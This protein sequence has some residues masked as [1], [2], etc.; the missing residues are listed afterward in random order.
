MLTLATDEIRIAG[1]QPDE[2]AILEEGKVWALTVLTKSPFGADILYSLAGDKAFIQG[3]L[4]FWKAQ[5]LGQVKILASGLAFP[6]SGNSFRCQD[7]L[8]TQLEYEYDHRDCPHILNML[9]SSARQA[10]VT[11]LYKLATGT[12]SLTKGGS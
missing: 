5:P 10:A 11:Y 3:T 6:S 8:I 9:Y 7:V 4:D 1:L 12:H 2:I